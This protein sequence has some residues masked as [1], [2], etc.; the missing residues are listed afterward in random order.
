MKVDNVLILSAGKGTRMGEIGKVLPKVLWPV[1]E[2]SLIKI[3]VEYAK[4]LAPNAKVFAN[5]Y[6][7]K[8][9]VKKALIDLDCEI[10]EEQEVLDIG[11][12]VHNLG[13]KLQYSGT[14]LVLNGDQFLSFDPKFFEAGLE[15][16][17]KY[18]SIL[19]SYRV[20]SNDLYN[21]LDEKDGL[22]NG[23]IPNKE[24]DRNTEHI[25]YTG[26]SLINLEKLNPCI[27]ESK[28]FDTVANP[29]TNRVGV[30]G[31]ENVE[32]WDFGTLKRYCESM[33]GLLSANYSNFRNF[34][35]AN[36]F[37]DESKINEKGYFTSR[38]INLTGEYIDDCLNS[39]VLGKPAGKI[40]G[41]CVI[42]G[43]CSEK[44]PNH[45]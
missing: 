35:I 21:S 9:I 16:L 18:D 33:F 28:F 10:L 3:Q 38:G 17:N 11:G 29:T 7:Y 14:L 4:M 22:L 19:F 23:I 6:Y 36:E 41:D 1:F 40:P 27:G 32:Y 24:I 2:K 39:I 25:T 31:I 44:I 5:I 20:N 45:S 12:A 37:L 8:E 15:N 42:L 26:M 43:E 13:R 34:L 30:V